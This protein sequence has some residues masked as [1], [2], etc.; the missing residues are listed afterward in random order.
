VD[1]RHDDLPYQRLLD[2][3]TTTLSCSSTSCFLFLTVPV[4]AGRL[5]IRE[6]EEEGRNNE[7]VRCVQV[8]DIPATGMILRCVTDSS[9]LRFWL[10]IVRVIT[11]EIEIGYNTLQTVTT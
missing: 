10:Q 2:V 8:F 1:L 3:N 4:S 7:E 9:T 6:V 5:S 11:I